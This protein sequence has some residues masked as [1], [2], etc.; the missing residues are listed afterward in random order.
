MVMSVGGVMGVTVLMR[1]AT[2]NVSFCSGSASGAPLRSGIGSLGEL[3]G[4]VVAN[5]DG[6]AER[7]VDVAARVAAALCVRSSPGG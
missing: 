6:F 7:D 1:T 5:R 4:E 2:S 3:A